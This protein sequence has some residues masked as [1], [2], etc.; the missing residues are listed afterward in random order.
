MRSAFFGGAP[1]FIVD[2]GSSYVPVTQQ[3]MDLAD[4]DA[5]IEEQGSGGGAGNGYCKGV[6]RS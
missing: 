1:P 6:C 2:L 5:G 3:L 4:V